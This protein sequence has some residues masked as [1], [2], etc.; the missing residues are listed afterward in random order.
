VTFHK[1]ATRMTFGRAECILSLV[2]DLTLGLLKTAG[3][4]NATQ[5][6]RWFEEHLQEA[7]ALLIG[8]DALS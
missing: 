7:L 8:L 6:R 3:F 4:T 2:P 5:G 1:D